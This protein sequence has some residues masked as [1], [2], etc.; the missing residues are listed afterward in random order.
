MSD[1]YRNLGGLKAN[2]TRLINKGNNHLELEISDK[3][4]ELAEFL[5]VAFEKY[6]E[7]VKS[8]LAYSG[9]GDTMKGN[10]RREYAERV[11]TV[12]RLTNVLNG[13]DDSSYDVIDEVSSLPNGPPEV[14]GEVSND[15]SLD[16]NAQ[17]FL[18]SRNQSHVFSPGAN[19]DSSASRRGRGRGRGRPQSRQSR[20]RQ[21]SI[22][23][24]AS[25]EDEEAS[26]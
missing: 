5:E 24:V 15:S 25:Q 6:G 12:T 20:E 26:S 7:A 4:E 18:P 8:A 13:L 16:P 11:I 17:P 10:L 21:P 9:T 22:G 2:L 14:N 1:N 19:N 3:Y 23:S